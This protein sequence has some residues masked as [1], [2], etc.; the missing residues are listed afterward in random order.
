MGQYLTGADLSFFLLFLLPRID[1]LRL[2]LEQRGLNNISY[3]I[4]NSQDHKSRHMYP[5]LRNK[6]SVNIPVYNHDNLQEDVWKLLSGDKDDFLIY[7]R[8]V[9]SIFFFFSI[10]RYV[11]WMQILGNS[12]F[13]GKKKVFC[14]CWR[15]TFSK[16]M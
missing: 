7:D 4:V 12:Y 14:C 1:D 13:V 8:F 10:M 6:V 3:M 16:A 9:C 11:I 2:K 5:L 15:Q